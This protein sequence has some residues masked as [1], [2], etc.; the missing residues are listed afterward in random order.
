[1]SVAS[2][3]SKHS[4]APS[5]CNTASVN[6]AHTGVLTVPY[7]PLPPSL[8]SFFSSSPDVPEGTDV[9]EI[10]DKHSCS[11]V[12]RQLEECL[13]ANDRKWAKCQVLVKSLQSCNNQASNKDRREEGK[14]TETRREAGEGK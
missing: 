7:I 2:I 10:I 6:T 8:P 3:T 14:A 13:A 1:M 11:V 9:D 12:Y 5:P 4:H